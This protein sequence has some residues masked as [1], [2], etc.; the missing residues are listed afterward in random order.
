MNWKDFAPNDPAFDE[1]ARTHGLHP[2]HVEDCRSDEQQAR[3]ELGE[4]QIFVL[5]KLIALKSNDELD[6]ADL[7]LFLGDY[8]VTVHRTPVPDVTKA[9]DGT[10]RH[11]PRTC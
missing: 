9:D 3:V 7:D 2:S 1:F 8:L 4:G 11:P 5:L 10:S 6:L